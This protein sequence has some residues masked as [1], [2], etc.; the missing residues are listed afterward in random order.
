MTRPNFFQ[1][2]LS[3]NYPAGVNPWNGQP[4]AVQP[5]GTWFTPN[6]KVAA[7]D[8]NWLFGTFTQ[9]LRTAV[10]FCGNGAMLNWRDII[11]PTGN[12]TVSGSPRET[13]GPGSW[14]PKNVEWLAAYRTGADNVIEFVGTRTQGKGWYLIGT[15]FV[16]QGWP[17][18]VKGDP[19]NGQRYVATVWD[20][21]NGRG[22][23]YH[24]DLGVV[25]SWS[26]VDIF[27]NANATTSELH[28]FTPGNVWV[29]LYGGAKATSSPDGATWTT[30]TIPA[31]GGLSTATAWSLAASSS[32]LMAVPRVAG[33]TNFM[34]SLDGLTWTAGTLPG[35][36]GSEVPSGIACGQN[37]AGDVW[38]IAISTGSGSRFLTSTDNGTTWTSAGAIGGAIDSS[39]ACLA[40]D[41]KAFGNAFVCALENTTQRGGHVFFSVDFGVTW[42]KSNVILTD[43]VAVGTA[44]YQRVRL[45]ASPTGFM[46]TDA[47]ELAL[48]W[49]C[50]LP[51]VSY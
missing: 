12:D 29:A 45:Q 38:M 47:K 28:F 25:S 36:G 1:W 14:N 48:S 19:R 50:G 4:L 2:S 22:V 51:D 6:T 49:D 33:A 24:L 7:E 10:D 9:G 41:L 3:G 40:A 26:F 35:L 20:S 21:F 23:I 30:R 5:A 15:G 42:R 34:Y 37:Y 8:I 31:T 17:C 32:R 46:L 16:Q 27:T 18:Q 11:V 13:W 39:G 44:G 43:N